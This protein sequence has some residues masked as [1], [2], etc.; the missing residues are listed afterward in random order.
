MMS[1]EDEEAQELNEDTDIITL[2]VELFICTH[3]LMPII[4]GEHIDGAQYRLFI[5]RADEK[6]MAYPSSIVCAH[7]GRGI[8]YEL[9]RFKDDEHSS[10]DFPYCSVL[11]EC[12]KKGHRWQVD[13]DKSSRILMMKRLASCDVENIMGSFG[14]LL[15]EAEYYV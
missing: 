10:V 1:L 11:Y 8:F 7:C 14:A 6:P 5:V 3:H 15:G 2:D 12:L 9:F 4:L 13:M